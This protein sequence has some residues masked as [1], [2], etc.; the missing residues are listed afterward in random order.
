MKKI[1]LRF[2]K[3]VF[4]CL[5]REIDQNTV[6]TIFVGATE[7]HVFHIKTKS[8]NVA[9]IRKLAFKKLHE[10]LNKG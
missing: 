7:T 3:E 5:I 2:L 9:Y 8:Q 4:D 6:K 10:K 1:E